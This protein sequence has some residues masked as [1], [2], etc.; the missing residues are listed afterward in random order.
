[1]RLTLLPFSLVLLMFCSTPAKQEETSDTEED[2]LTYMELY[3]LVTLET[4]NRIEWHGEDTDKSAA[5]FLTITEGESCG[6]NDCGKA[7]YLEN[8]SENLIQVIIQAPFQIEDVSSHLATRYS[9]E[10]KSKISIGC[11][12]LCYD[13]E[14]YLFERRVV[15]AKVSDEPFGVNNN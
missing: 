8:S 1:M 9:I 3:N 13:G 15:G 7:V 2:Q 11:S 6:E 5:E 12:H 10:G 14:A 4:G